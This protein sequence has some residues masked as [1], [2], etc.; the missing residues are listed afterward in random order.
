MKKKIF[1][2][3]RNLPSSGRNKKRM[4]TALA[5]LLVLVCVVCG[6]TGCM[7]REEGLEDVV[8][9]DTSEE[10]YGVFLGIDRKTFDISL[11]ENYKQVVVDA[12]ELSRD[13]LARLHEN[14]HV[15]YS[16]LNVGSIENTR[17]YF[18][19]YE[20]ICLDSYDNWPDEYWVDVTQQK[21][22]DF[23]GV[24]LVNTIRDKDPIIDGLFLDNLDVYY[25]VQDT[26]KYRSMKEDV[27]DAL[28]SILETYQSAGLPVLVN[29]A[30]VFVSQMIE[31]GLEDLVPG[32]NQET[33]FSS[34]RDYDKDKF[35]EQ[36]KSEN[37]YYIEYLADC[38][39]AGI[40]IYLLEYTRDRT[41]KAKICKFCRE[42]G[43]RFFISEYVNLDFGVHKQGR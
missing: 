10:S 5:T 16:Y 28:V 31:E 2:V 27:F 8:I 22:K 17:D 9:S 24:T 34:I 29:G 39:E 14:G 32:V 37:K 42:N 11:F 1:R 3:C 25:H 41:V 7:G 35:G 26:K 15:V 40:D 13:Q 23:V 36:P 19:E 12:Q 6:V 20:D 30:D 18:D 43:Y 33:V 21:W 38:E 4:T